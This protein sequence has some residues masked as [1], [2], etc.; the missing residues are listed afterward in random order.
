MFRRV[1]RPLLAAAAIPA[2][3]TPDAPALVGVSGGR[4]SVALLHWLHACGFKRLT[5]C[6][7]DH[8]LRPESRADARFVRD[9]A[10]RLGCQCVI[11]RASVSAL[12]KRRKLSIETAAR[13]ARHAFF[14]RCAKA[15]RTA[16]LFLAHH[17]D[18]QVETFLFNLLRGAGPGGFGGMAPVTVLGPLTVAR[19]FLAVWREDIEAYVAAHALMWREDASNAELEFTRNR[20]R[21]VAIPALGDTMGRDV[22]RALW[23][24]AE[25]LRAEDEC[26]ASQLPPPPATLETKVLAALPLAI[27]RRVIHA[28]LSARRIA[29]VGFEEVETVRSLLSLRVAKVNLPGGRHARR[30]AGRIFCE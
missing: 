22:R 29:S 3:F 8:G 20:L 27:Q 9:F 24:A 15:Q 30:R 28:W 23:R 18:D 2:E 7:L 6:H 13:D 10:G 12:A 17:A 25:L 4:D 16:R 5:V 14:A 21:H 19:P 11:S 26:T 1:P